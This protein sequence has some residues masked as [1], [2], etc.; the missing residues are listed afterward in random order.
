MTTSGTVTLTKPLTST[1]GKLAIVTSGNVNTFT[2][3][4]CPTVTV[5]TSGTVTLTKP[6]TSTGGK[7]AI[8]TSGKLTTETLGVFITLTSPQIGNGEAATIGRGTFKTLTP[9]GFSSCSHFI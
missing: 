3:I 4:G 8:V 2:S 9:I 6:L 1:G 5:T 7:L